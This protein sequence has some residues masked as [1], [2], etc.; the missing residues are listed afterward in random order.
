[1]SSRSPFVASAPSVACTWTFRAIS[2]RDCSTTRPSYNHGRGGG[3]FM[4]LNSR[5]LAEG[6]E[7]AL[8][9]APRAGDERGFPRLTGRYRPQRPVHCFRML[10]SL[11][12]AAD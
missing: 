5:A 3:I 2:G 11:P 9:S 7:S 1:M 8:L 12:Y 10:G 4:T 6:D